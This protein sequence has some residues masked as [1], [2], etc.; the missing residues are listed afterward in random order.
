M[1]TEREKTEIEGWRERRRHREKE[2]WR[3]KEREVCV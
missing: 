1:K 2:T 3:E